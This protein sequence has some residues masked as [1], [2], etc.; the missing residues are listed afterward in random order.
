MEKQIRNFEIDYKL[1][2]TY[3]VE[4]SKIKNDIEKLEKLG[5]THIDIEM[6]G[7]NVDELYI[8]VKASVNRLETD[9]EYNLRIKKENSSK[10]KPI[11]N[12]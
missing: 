1:N 5:A 4:I 6:N 10:I 12:E 9:D 8:E 7:N 11:E 3:G 2:W